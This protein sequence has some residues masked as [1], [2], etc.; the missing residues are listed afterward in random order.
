MNAFVHV[1]RLG[2]EIEPSLLRAAALALAPVPLCIYGALLLRKRGAAY[3]EVD[4][5]QA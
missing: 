4:R 3:G 2:V 1:N 5:I